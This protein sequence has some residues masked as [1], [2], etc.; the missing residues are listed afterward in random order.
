MEVVLE[1]TQGLTLKS[2][3]STGE[4]QL[5]EITT[6]KLALKVSQV[7]PG[8]GRSVNLLQVETKCGVLGLALQAKAWATKGATLALTCS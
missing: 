1:Q 2:F 5:W 3:A 6:S 7:A 8:E 4:C